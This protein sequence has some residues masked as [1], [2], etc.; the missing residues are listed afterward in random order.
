MATAGRLIDTSVFAGASAAYSLRIPEGSPYNG[1]LIRV[2]RTSDNA[3]QDINAGPADGNGNRWID[4]A[5]LLAFCGASD[6]RVATWYD[7]SGNGRN[8]TQG[9]G[10]AQPRIVLNGVL[11]TEG[12]KPCL[13]FS[14]TQW[15]VTPTILSR[16]TYPFAFVNCVYRNTT[17]NSG[18]QALWGGDGGTWPRFQLLNF[19]SASTISWG[20]SDGAAAAQQTALMANT[21]RNI[22]SYNSQIPGGSQVFI[23]GASGVAFTESGNGMPTA[24]TIGAIAPGGSY[25]LLGSV[26]EF[27]YAFGA[28]TNATRQALERSQGAAFGITVA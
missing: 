14:G 2:R 3:E 10:S 12:G 21:N 17:I 27:I 13:V 25:Q 20:T 5:A 1:P 7:R 8:A 22:Y 26:S 18:N 28:L 4:Q 19:A 6:G 15:L 16:T 23:N 9:T 11:D 24:L